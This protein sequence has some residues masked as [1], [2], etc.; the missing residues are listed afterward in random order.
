MMLYTRKPLDYFTRYPKC[1]ILKKNVAMASL[2]G[3]AV[4]KIRVEKVMEQIQ[5]VLTGT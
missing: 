3:E 2:I 1:F 4:A 5:N